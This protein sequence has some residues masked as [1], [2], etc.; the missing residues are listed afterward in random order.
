MKVSV[1]LFEKKEEVVMQDVIIN[2]NGDNRR[3]S[4]SELD[5]AIDALDNEE[6]GDNDKQL[7]IA[8][9]QTVLSGKQLKYDT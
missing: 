9:L 8:V 3:I 2:V 6:C 4:N 5:N 1:Q 7:I